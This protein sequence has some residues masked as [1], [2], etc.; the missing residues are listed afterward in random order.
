[1]GEIV[2]ILQDRQCNMCRVGDGVA[3]TK[4]VA[5]DGGRGL[6]VRRPAISCNFPKVVGRLHP[7]NIPMN[8]RRKTVFCRADD[9]ATRLCILINAVA[10]AK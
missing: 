3:E 9:L 7:V 4:L 6:D 8:I 1:M 5:C 10:G 2:D